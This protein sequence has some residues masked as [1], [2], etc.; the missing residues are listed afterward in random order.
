MANESDLKKLINP[1][2]SARVLLRMAWC[3][4]FI[5]VGSGLL[6]AFVMLMSATRQNRAETSQ[7]AVEFWTVGLVAALPFVL[8]AFSELAKIPLASAFYHTQRRFWKLAFLVGLLFLVGITFETML[9]GLETNFATRTQRV[10]DIQMKLGGAVE[11]LTAVERRIGDLEL[12][13]REEVQ[14]NTDDARSLYSSQYKK[15]LDAVRVERDE[16]RREIFFALEPLTTQGKEIEAKM[17][18]LGAANS[19]ERAKLE[20]A[21]QV[22]LGRRTAMSND[23][24]NA[25][26]KEL[27]EIREAIGELDATEAQELRDRPFGGIL[28]GRREIEVKYKDRREAFTERRIVLE[29]RLDQVG[30][31]ASPAPELIRLDRRLEELGAT[32][33]WEN[34]ALD[35]GLKGINRKIEVL[36]ESLRGRWETLSQGFD[37]REKGLLGEHKSRIEALDTARKKSLEDLQAQEEELASLQDHRQELEE[38]KLRLRRDHERVAAG[39]QIHRLTQLLSGSES[40]ADVSPEHVRTVSVVWFGSL[41]ATVAS[42]GTLLALAA[43]VVANGRQSPAP[44]QPGRVRGSLRKAL[45]SVRKFIVA[46]RRRRGRVLVKTEI[47]EVVKEVPVEKIVVKEVEV[48]KIVTREIPIE[49]P[50]PIET[51]IHEIKYVPVPMNDVE[52]LLSGSEIPVQVNGERRDSNVT[53]L[54]R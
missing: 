49:K 34:A 13:T 10:K 1:Q 2:A 17:S 46:E 28:G 51:K 38:Q 35:R 24:R 54:S 53:R 36:R 43:N 29:K 52:G 9:T 15:E 37:A 3:F 47:K 22:E 7:P 25:I 44:R 19:K 26:E 20:H 23:E 12:V 4:E 50:V 21:R 11:G 32:H 5:A 45:R 39:S 6:I 14:G 18:A 48:E 27:N 16:K 42:I 40:A 8:V 30:V 31:V 41:A 33:A